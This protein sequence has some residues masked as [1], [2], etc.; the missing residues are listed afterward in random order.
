MNKL[1]LTPEQIEYI[2]KLIAE[3][4]ISLDNQNYNSDTYSKFK[5]RV[6]GLERLLGIDNYPHNKEKINRIIKY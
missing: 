5:E 6:K 1:D 4:H 2:S 3:C